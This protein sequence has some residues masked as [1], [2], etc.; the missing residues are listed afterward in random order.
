MVGA[1]SPA[2]MTI[3]SEQ[4]VIGAAFNPANK[5]KV[6]DVIEG[7]SGVFVIRVNN[8]SATPVPNAN[9]AEQRKA[10][11]EQAKQQAMYSSPLQALREDASIKDRRSKF[12]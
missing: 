3:A 7:S 6:S 11:Y 2:A 12:F 4:K 1:Q 10:R 8:I 9:V 5:G